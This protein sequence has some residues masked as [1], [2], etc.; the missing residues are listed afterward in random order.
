MD[1]PCISSPREVIHKLYTG[2]RLG[3]NLVWPLI[4]EYNLLFYKGFIK[5][6]TGLPGPYNNNKIQLSN[7]Y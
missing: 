1:N 7:Y 5:L 4:F 3:V 6:S 2:D